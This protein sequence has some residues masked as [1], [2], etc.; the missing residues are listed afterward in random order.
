MHSPRTAVGGGFW[1]SMHGG[2][3]GNPGY[4]LVAK[5]SVVPLLRPGAEGSNA[6]EVLALQP[7][8]RRGNGCA[9]I[10]ATGLRMPVAE[11]RACY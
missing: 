5:V 8:R 2:Y 10:T 7:S 6:P 3:R 1:I 9:N 11:V 4:V